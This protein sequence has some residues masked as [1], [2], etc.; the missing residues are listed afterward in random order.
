MV[1]QSS[2]ARE[3]SKTSLGRTRQVVSSRMSSKFQ[4]KLSVTVHE[5]DGPRVLESPVLESVLVLEA[6]KVLS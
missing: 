4:F 2:V 6:T 3:R 1:S 5:G